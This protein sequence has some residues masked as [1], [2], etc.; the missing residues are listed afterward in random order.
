MG[1]ET[2]MNAAAFFDQEMATHYD[3]RNSQLSPMSENLHFLMRMVLRDVP[4]R[5]DILCIGVG[6]GA[7]IFALATAFPN[8]RFV[9]VDPSPDML[10]V[11]RQKLEAAGLAERCELV[12]GHLADLSDRRFDAIVS[13]LV[14][15]FVSAGERP[16][17]YSGS[18]D[19]L[20]PGGIYVSAEICFDL[21]SPQF[22]SA[23]ENWKQVQIMMGATPASLD[24][25]P[26]ML[27]DTLTV[28]SPEVTETLARKAGLGLPVWFFQAFLIR[29]WYS[30]I[31]D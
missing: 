12:Q 9:G 10:E 13:L 4:E 24:K 28:L 15:H 22:P 3:E 16:A 18:R 30:R 17:F 29:G 26:T 2:A 25:L 1:K 23:L 20:K 14:A 21:D 11:C 19:R 6:T 8:W 7:D 31:A 5:A 27:R